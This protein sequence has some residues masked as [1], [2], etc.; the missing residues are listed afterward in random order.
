MAR[1]RNGWGTCVNCGET[2]TPDGA[3]E[4]G[5]SDRCRFCLEMVDV[6]DIINPRLQYIKKQLKTCS[7][8]VWKIDHGITGQEHWQ[9]RLDTYQDM[10]NA[11]IKVLNLKASEDWNMSYP[12][13]CN[14]IRRSR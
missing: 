14:P 13:S 4:L 11:L 7:D 12:P 3:E 2:L 1:Q 9:K 5:W 10:R 8:E 6:F